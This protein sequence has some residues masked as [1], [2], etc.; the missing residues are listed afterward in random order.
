MADNTTLDNVLTGFSIV[1]FVTPPDHTLPIN[2]EYLLYTIDPNLQHFSFS[3]PYIPTT[4]GFDG[5]TVADT[6]NTPLAVNNRG[7]LVQAMINN[8]LSVDSNINISVLADAN[9]NYLMAEPVMRLLGEE[10][11]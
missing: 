2:I 1:P 11:K 8:G 9:T 5:D 6:I 7:L 10:K 3:N 4:D